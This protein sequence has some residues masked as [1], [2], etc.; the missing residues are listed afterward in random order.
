MSD[1]QKNWI[2]W[3]IEKVDKYDPLINFHDHL[4]KSQKNAYL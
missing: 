4:F 1:E 2:Q 3:A